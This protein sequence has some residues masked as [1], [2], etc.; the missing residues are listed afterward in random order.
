MCPELVGK[1]MWRCQQLKGK[2]ASVFGRHD[3]G[4]GNPAKGQQVT[5]TISPD[6]STSLTA[7]TW[8]GRRW[9]L[10]GSLWHLS[11]RR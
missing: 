1:V 3:C 6:S 11:V 2:D 7:C 4:L 10:A 5:A 9:E 8:P